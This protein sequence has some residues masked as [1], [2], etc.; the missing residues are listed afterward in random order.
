MDMHAKM[1]IFGL[2]S[3]MNLF[4]DLKHSTQVKKGA[5]DGTSRQKS[6]DSGG[7]NV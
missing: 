2:I 1:H 7:V 6:C 5:D 3:N 4:L